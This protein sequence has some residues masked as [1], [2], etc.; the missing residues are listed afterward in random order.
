MPFNQLIPMINL[1]ERQVLHQFIVLELA[2]QTLQKDF[3]QLEQLKLKMLYMTWTERL[4]NILYPIY[5]SQ[6]HAL[7]EKHIRVI[8]WR[9]IDEY[10]SEVFIATSSEVITLQYKNQAIKVEV[11]QFLQSV[12]WRN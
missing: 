9:K 7:S 8:R 10:F 3:D 6:K 11:E 2:I 5:H 1:Q 4:L 12:V